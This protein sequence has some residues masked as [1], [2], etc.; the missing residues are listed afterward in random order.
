[1]YICA[2]VCI[3]LC[4]FK[5]PSAAI[6]PALQYPR[7]VISAPLPGGMSFRG[8]TT[9]IVLTVSPESMV[10]ATAGRMP[11]T[12]Q[13]LNAWIT[14]W[15]EHPVH[16]DALLHPGDPGEFMLVDYNRQ[17]EI[18][19]SVDVLDHQFGSVAATTPARSH[20]LVVSAALTHS[21]ADQGGEEFTR[22]FPHWKTR[23]IHHPAEIQFFVTVT[24]SVARRTF[25]MNK[26]EHRQATFTDI[27]R[28]QTSSG[29]VRNLRATF[30]VCRFHK[31]HILRTA[32]T[33][34]ALADLYCHEFLSSKSFGLALVPLA[35]LSSLFVMGPVYED[36]L[37]KSHGTSTLF[38]VNPVN[39]HYRS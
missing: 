21:L 4:L 32:W 24:F 15:F 22:T 33:F 34:G 3:C 5:S 1:M 35:H 38:S 19:H 27:L 25:V 7:P 18:N 14:K 8:K 9:S 16:I 39:P 28:D 26:F 17:V 13:T 29:L 37:V 2:N 12:R 10:I 6:E 11:V 31:F 36:E 20:V 23:P 30:A